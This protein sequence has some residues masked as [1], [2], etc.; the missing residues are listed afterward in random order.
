MSS[1]RCDATESRKAK[2]RLRLCVWG[3]PQKHFAAPLG[4]HSKCLD[5]SFEL[6]SSKHPATALFLNRLG[7]RV[8]ENTAQCAM[9]D[10]FTK[11]PASGRP[12]AAVCRPQDRPTTSFCA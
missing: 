7:G 6:R 3:L 1:Q 8:W 5:K 12:L 4:Q 2:P 10:P 11:D 9:S